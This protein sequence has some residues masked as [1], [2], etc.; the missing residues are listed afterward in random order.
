MMQAP[1]P[2]PASGGVYRDTGLDLGAGAGSTYDFNIMMLK[3][4]MDRLTRQDGGQLT[5]AHQAEL[6][7]ELD[8]LNHRFSPRFAR[9]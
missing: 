6:Q 3:K 4:K 8:A 9:R 5:A 1:L 7:K 2:S